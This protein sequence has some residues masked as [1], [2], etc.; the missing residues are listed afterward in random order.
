MNSGIVEA[1]RQGLRETGYTENKNIK[2]EFLWARGSQRSPAGAG[3]RADRPP[4]HRHRREQRLGDGSKGRDRDDTDRVPER[5]RSRRQRPRRQPR[6]SRR[7]H[8]G[9]E[10]FCVHAGVK[11][12]EV[13]HELIPLA[14]RHRRA[15]EPEQPAGGY[16]G[17][18]N[19]GGRQPAAAPAHDP[20]GRQ[21]RRHR[22]GLRDPRATGGESGRGRRRSV[23]Q[24]PAQAADRAGR[25]LH[26]SPRSTRTAK[27]STKAG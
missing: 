24:Q 4:G 13:M 12:L 10:L 15:R 23:F 21:R 1:F 11:K 19:A 2:I 16:P 22:R 14:G 17:Q 3:G 5:R 7:Q 18:R 27:M 8:D 6:P 9:R 20:R 25:T 26:G